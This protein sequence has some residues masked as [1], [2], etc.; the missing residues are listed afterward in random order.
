MACLCKKYKEVLLFEGTTQRIFIPLTCPGN[1]WLTTIIM[2]TTPTLSLNIG[3]PEWKNVRAIY[4]RLS[5]E[6]EVL[7]QPYSIAL[8]PVQKDMLD[9]LIIA[10]DRIDDYIDKIDDKQQQD[11]VVKYILQ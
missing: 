1:Y 11:A 3:P 4:K 2:A 10:I 8:S 6:F 5:D 9:H 7:L